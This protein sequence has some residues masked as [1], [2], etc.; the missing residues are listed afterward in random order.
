[1]TA[2]NFIIKKYYNKSFFIKEYNAFLED[3]GYKKSTKTTKNKFI[4][5][6]VDW[7]YK[8]H[9]LKITEIETAGEKIKKFLKG[10]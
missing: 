2:N 4:S 1:M 7:L 5:N 8:L 10:V 3:N 9:G 6:A